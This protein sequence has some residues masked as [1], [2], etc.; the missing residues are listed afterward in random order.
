VKYQGYTIQALKETSLGP[1]G[2]PKEK[3]VVVTSY[4]VKVGDKVVAAGLPNELAAKRVVDTRRKL[5]TR[6]GLEPAG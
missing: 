6:V 5:R 3:T 4:S 1:Q 2:D